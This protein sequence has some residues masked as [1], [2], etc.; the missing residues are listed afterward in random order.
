[1]GK[2]NFA[3]TAAFLAL[4]ATQS[5]N[6]KDAYDNYCDNGLGNGEDYLINDLMVYAYPLYEALKFL[7]EQKF[8]NH[9]G[10]VLYE[11]CEE[12]GGAWASDLANRKDSLP[13]MEDVTVTLRKY[14]VAC[15]SPTNEEENY[16]INN[17]MIIFNSLLQNKS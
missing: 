5:D 8:T 7:Q 4:G 13:E 15:F 14:I 17:A 2:V 6:Y 11:V 10:V 9:Y 1:M 16:N 12:L 3:S